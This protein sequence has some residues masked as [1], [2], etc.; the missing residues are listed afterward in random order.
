[1]PLTLLVSLS[2]PLQVSFFLS[3]S[4]CPNITFPSSLPLCVCWVTPVVS[5]SSL[6]CGL[7]PTRLLCPWDPA[8]KNTG[9]GCHALFQGTFPTQGS[10]L[11]LLCLLL[12]QTGSLSLAPPR[13]PKSSFTG[14]FSYPVR[15]LS[16]LREL[17]MDREAWC[18]AV[19]GVTKSRTRLSD[20]TFLP[21]ARD[22][23]SLLLSTFRSDHTITP[24]CGLLYAGLISRSFTP[25]QSLRHLTSIARRIFALH[26]TSL[27]RTHELMDIK[28]SVRCLLRTRTQSNNNYCCYHSLLIY[29]CGWEQDRSPLTLSSLEL[30]QRNLHRGYVASRQWLG[31]PAAAVSSHGSGSLPWVRSGRGRQKLTD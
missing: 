29:F 30:G 25:E 17:V 21:R 4:S 10:N 3:F 15:S 1:M 5:D 11:C 8:S 7:E 6:P 12:W 20:W 26:I 31:Q 16:K 14:S 27:W 9:V 28:F 22:I 18:A 23:C 2:A 19:H 13:K 24:S